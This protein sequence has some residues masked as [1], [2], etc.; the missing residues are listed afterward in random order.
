MLDF[1][2]IDK[3]LQSLFDS[4]EVMQDQA[5]VKNLNQKQ[6]NTIRAGIIQ[7][8]EFTYELSWKF[9]KRWLENNL[10]STEVDG[11][12]RRQ[13]FRLAAESQLITDIEL[14]M[15][16]HKYRNLTAHTYDENTAKEVENISQPFSMACQ[17][18]VKTLKMKND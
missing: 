13:L 3:A 1:T 11:V 12:S 8:F 7:N 4:L 18:L 10:S 16:F 14:W 5:F 17:Q 9:M 15:T 6:I 2:A